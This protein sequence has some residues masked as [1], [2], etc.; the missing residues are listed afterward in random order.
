MSTALKRLLLRDLTKPFR[1][2]V[3]DNCTHNLEG[4]VTRTFDIRRRDLLDLLQETTQ[5]PAGDDIVDRVDIA[6]YPE[7]DRMTIHNPSAIDRDAVA[8]IRRRSM[9]MVEWEREPQYGELSERLF[10]ST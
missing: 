2:D 6:E 1:I 9:G 7:E 3:R 5:T 10:K 8:P 4:C